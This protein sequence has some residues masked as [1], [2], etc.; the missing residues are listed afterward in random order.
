MYIGEI[1]GQLAD[2]FREH[3]KDIINGRNDIPVWSS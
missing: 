3:P 2:R 1:G